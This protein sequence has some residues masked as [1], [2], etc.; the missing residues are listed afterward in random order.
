[1]GLIDLAKLQE[2]LKQ[3]KAKVVQ[4]TIAYVTKEREEFE[5]AATKK[6]AQILKDLPKTL[7]KLAVQGKASCDLLKLDPIGYSEDR[8]PKMCKIYRDF[9]TAL[10]AE[11]LLVKVIPKPGPP[12]GDRDKSPKWENWIEV[13]IPEG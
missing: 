4:D 7:G 12:T 13:T 3:G 1:M 10:E 6:V 5:A 8:N 11:G 9:V 2:R